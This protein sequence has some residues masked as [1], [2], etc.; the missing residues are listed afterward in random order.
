VR[1]RSKTFSEDRIGQLLGDAKGTVSVK[2]M[3]LT[4]N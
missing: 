2:E 3:T 4:Q 1:F